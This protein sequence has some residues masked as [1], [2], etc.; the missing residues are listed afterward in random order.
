MRRRR[1]RR[2]SMPYSLPD[3]EMYVESRRSRRKAPAARRTRPLAPRSLPR[4]RQGWW[5]DRRFACTGEVNAPG[6][7]DRDSDDKV[8]VGTTEEGRYAIAPLAAK[9]VTN[10]SSFPDVEQAPSL[11]QDRIVCARRK[12]GSQTKTCPRRRRSCRPRRRQSRTSESCSTHR[13]NS[14]MQPAI[15]TDDRDEAVAPPRILRLRRV[16]G[17]WQR[18]LADIPGE[19]NPPQRVNVH[20]GLSRAGQQRR[21]IDERTRRIGESLLCAPR[22]SGGG[23]RTR[24]ATPPERRIP[25]HTPRIVSRCCDL[26]RNCGVSGQHGGGGRHVTA[27]RLARDAPRRGCAPVSAGPRLRDCFPAY[28]AV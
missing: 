4:R 16:G 5:E 9:R 3:P 8:R 7:I 28:S 2:L 27:T 14:R 22:G 1:C 18:G 21:R 11:P 25:M 20:R 17:H 24:N 6:T 13:D 19:I 15:G 26:S 10:P 23:K 12:W